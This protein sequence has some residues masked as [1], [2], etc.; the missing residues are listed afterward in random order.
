MKLSSI[1]KLSIIT[2][3]I[4]LSGCGSDDKENALPTVVSESVTVNENTPV[5]IT[6][7][8]TDSDGSISSYSWQQTGGQSVSLSGTSTGSL[9]FTAPSVAEAGESLTFNVTVTDDNGDTA[10]TSSTVTINNVAPSGSVED[11]TVDE[12]STVTVTA[13]ISG[14]GDEIA[15]YSWVQ[16][17]GTTVA[18]S[19]ADTTTLTFTAPE[20]SS[21]EVIGLSLTATDTDDDSV[22]IESVV[23]VNQIT[24]PLTINGLATDS[25][26]ANG[27]ISVNVSGRDITVDVTADENGV[28]SV[29]LLLDDSEANAFISITAHGVAEQVNA[30]LITLLGTAGQLSAKAGEDNV[31]TA[32]ESFAVNVTNIT[33]AQ[34][35]LAK[36]ANNGETITTDAKLQSLIQALNYNEVLT[37][38]TA[39]KVAIDKAGA[40]SNLALPQGTENT[41]D[42]VENVAATQAYVQLVVSKPEFKE[43]KEE[44]LE[45]ASLVDTSS[46]WNI[47][48]TYFLLPSGSLT[49]GFI[50]RFNADGSGSK[51]EDNFNWELSEG[52]VTAN[53][54]E[55]DSTVFESTAYVE[56]NGQFIQVRA[57]Y[58]T[59]NHSLKRMGSN[60]KGD[61]LLV[62]TATKTHYPDGELAD[63]VNYSST[64]YSA[65]KQNGTVDITHSGAGVA[66]LPFADDQPDDPKIV[67][68]MAD[69]FTLNADGTGHATILNLDFNWQ[70][71]NGILK[72][73][74]ES[75]GEDTYVPTWIQ[76]TTDL[77][78][79]Q[80]AHEFIENGQVRP[81]DD[82][83]GEGAILAEPMV[84]AESSV[85]G[86]YTYDN[87]T[88]ADPLEKFWFE[89]HANGDAETYS[90]R[91]RNE[92]G[93]LTEDELTTMYGSWQINADGTLVISRVRDQNVGY[94]EQC[95]FASTEGCVLYHERTWRL[96]GQ[97]DNAYS[98]F[99]KHDFKYSHFG[100]GDDELHYDN[101]TVFKVENPPVVFDDRSASTN[102]A[103]SSKLKV[104]STAKKVKRFANLEP[105][106]K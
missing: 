9:S 78:S 106:I 103:S 56:V 82:T 37:L 29:D 23:N 63:E 102:K 90:T 3:A 59:V 89:L 96:I 15:S 57:H 42:L 18:L 36:L 71:E 97:K 24:M 53:I 31:L 21:D 67:R 91:D 76:L 7:T 22:T 88:F 84:W 1:F 70:I 14:N 6:A 65:I 26:I 81:E 75:G 19:G 27:E 80:F 77:S 43:A 46:V 100:W 28:Y 66:Y 61:I 104:Q 13:D 38:A 12:K 74:I 95:R 60:E 62:K 41:L 50:F 10:E 52:V 16:T 99:H 5:T 11:Q 105:E 69:E 4:V 2:S 87:A 32:D 72:L 94:T 33:T 39:I 35:A 44:I 49:S 92:D 83:I 34:Y 64:T 55:N 20:T 48:E 73:D 98:L 47:P 51:G 8:A 85:P 30:G 93:T 40:N 58:S 54:I 17:S 45:D 86:I 25:P 101:R 68:L 79:N